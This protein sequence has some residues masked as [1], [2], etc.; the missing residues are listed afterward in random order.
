MAPTSNGRLGGYIEQEV[1]VSQTLATSAAGKVAALNVTTYQFS[2][3][4]FKITNTR[5]LHKDTDYVSV[6]LAVGNRPP[7]TKTK[8]MGDLNN[9]T[10]NVGL[11]FDNIQ[12]GDNETAVFSYA[13]VNNG[14]AS[15]SA[16]QSALQ[17]ATSTLASKGADA[18]AKVIGQEIGSVVGASIGT[19]VIPIVGT[20]LGALAGWLV[21]S[22]IGV[23]FANCDGPVAAGMHPLTAAQLKSGTAGGKAITQTDHN[24]GTDSAT[25]CGSN[26][27]YFVTW[28]VH[29]HTVA[30]K[31]E[32][33]A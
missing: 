19:A 16:V 29:A 22:A 24:P 21:S 23:A 3:D 15:S 31:V 28:S 33:K 32:A 18:A 12:V 8:A 14:H 5:S 10:F 11:S 17:K 6:S 2:L 20:A 26:S 27:N 9:G 25:G 13:I 1:I 4:N 30:T 7:V